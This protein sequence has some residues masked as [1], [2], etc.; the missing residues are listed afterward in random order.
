MSDPIIQNKLSRLGYSQEWLNSTVLTIEELEK[1]IIILEKGEDTNTEH[2]RYRTLLN[3]FNQ[4]PAFSNHVVEQLIELL[5]NDS[6]QTMAGSATA[7]L[8]D[9]L[10]LTNEQFDLIARFLQSFGIWALIRIERARSKRV[11]T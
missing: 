11:K 3:Y 8:L 9:R 7:Y 5:K 4:Q 6:D 1:Q 2:Y 10:S